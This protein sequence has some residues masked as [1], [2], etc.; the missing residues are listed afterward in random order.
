MRSN[1]YCSLE[2]E[3]KN[4]DHALQ[5][6]ELCPDDTLDAVLSKVGW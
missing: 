3:P 6:L 4:K 5:S 1:E 2:T